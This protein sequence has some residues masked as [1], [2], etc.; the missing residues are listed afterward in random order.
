[1]EALNSSTISQVSIFKSSNIV[2]LD[3]ILPAILIVLNGKI[4]RIHQYQNESDAERILNNYN[5]TVYDFGSS[6]LM[7]GIID[8]HVHVNEPGRSD[9]EGFE[10]ATRAAAAGG[11]TTIVDMPLNS[12]PPTTSLENLIVKVK[13]AEGKTSVDVGFWG[14]VIPGNEKHLRDLVNAGVVGFKCFMCPS[15]ID[16]FPYVQEKDIVSALNELRSLNSLLAF[17][18][19]MES[20]GNVS[21][22]YGNNPSFYSTFLETRPPSMELRALEVA[23]THCKNSRT[24]CHIVHL[25][26]A[27]G[28]KIIREAK[29]TGVNLTAE[30]CHHYLNIAAEDIPNGATQYKCTPPIRQKSNQDELWKAL[31]N[32]DLDMVVSDHSPCT[33]DLKT[34]GNFLTAWGGIASMQFD[35]SLMWTGAKQRNFSLI[36]VS[37]LLSANPAKVV[38]FDKFKGTIREGMDADFVIWNPEDKFIVKKSIIYHRNK[39]TPYEGRTLFGVVVATVVRGQFVY[40]EGKFADTP[41]G[42]L[43]L[44]KEFLA[45]IN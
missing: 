35:L 5:G 29:S 14:G 19:E 20:E 27:E 16:E 39:L 15:G 17:H 34:P 43:L 31:K 3:A 45:K 40:N 21:E 6:V 30:T 38:G 26:S 7:P 41:K 12:I 8:S 36:E 32:K 44:N 1:M 9:W 11:V 4:D 13:A 2:L 33:E 37:K 24:R 10:T 28:L 42:Q 25:S 22:P 18:A 23:T